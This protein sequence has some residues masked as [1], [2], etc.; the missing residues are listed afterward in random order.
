MGDIFRL[1]SSQYLK[2]NKLILLTL[3]AVAAIAYAEHHPAEADQAGLASLNQRD[4]RDAAPLKRKS[5]KGAARKKRPAVERRGRRPAGER[6][7]RRP[8]GERGG[9]KDRK[10]QQQKTLTNSCFA[11]S[12]K[13]MKMWK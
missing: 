6:G 10:K 2:M 3:I 5:S 1:L 9:K 8:A 7:G 11:S 13:A 12:M 4:V